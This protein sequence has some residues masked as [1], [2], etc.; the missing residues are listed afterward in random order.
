MRE[1]QAGFGHR[2]AAEPEAPAPT[3]RHHVT[4]DL[5]NVQLPWNMPFFTKNPFF[6]KDSEVPVVAQS[7]P[8][9]LITLATKVGLSLAAAWGIHTADVG[10]NKMDAEKAAYARSG[11][12]EHHFLGQS[13]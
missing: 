5:R 2:D 4:V 12:Y 8:R 10:T 11:N 13:W 1:R 9:R 7:M 3:Q 6:P